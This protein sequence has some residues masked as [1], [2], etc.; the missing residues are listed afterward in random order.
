MIKK[1]LRF[2]VAISLTIALCICG[3]SFILGLTVPSLSLAQDTQ[4]SYSSGKYEVWMTDQNNTA[5]YSSAAPRGT[6]GGRLLIYDSQ[7]LDKSG[8]AADR[9]TTI[10]LATV[11]A[12]DSAANPTGANVVRPHM[13]AVSPDGRFVALAFVTSGH[14]AIF[15]GNTKQPKALFRMSPGSGGAIQA[16]AAFWTPDGKALIVANQ[17][18]K[19]LERIDYNPGTDTFFHNRA[20]T[21]DLVNCTTP[22]GNL[23]QTNTPISDLD[24]AFWGDN[25]RPDNAPICPIVTPTHA[26]ITLRGGGLFVVDPTVTPMKV[27]AAYGNRFIGRDGC[28]GT[29][30]KKNVYLNAG[31]GTLATNPT[32]FTLYHLR[33]RFPAA[34]TTLPDNFLPLSPQTFYKSDLAERD[35]H[36][37]LVTAGNVKYLW[38][39]DRLSNVA[40]VFRLPSKQRVNT[41]DLKASGVS[42]DPTPDIVG[43]SP[44]GNRIYVALRGP[45][46]QTGAHASSGTTP[47]LGIVN[48][49]HNGADGTLSQVLPTSFL[50]AFDG[51]EESDPHGLVIRLKG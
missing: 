30:V 10:D 50:N 8:E 40:E 17:N 3:G 51:S 5:G 49:T 38:Q 16:H 35:A 22:S 11:F 2:Y 34:P 20:A 1:S 21:I 29:L 44:A 47:G 39:F 27:V 24:P 31:T 48:L 15:D 6:H 13:V 14:V 4:S 7:D 36:G 46:P 25:N 45:R 33:D 37:M 18:G 43:L 9:A 26:F 41:V 42:S 12:I 23:C 19:L 28:G 32:E